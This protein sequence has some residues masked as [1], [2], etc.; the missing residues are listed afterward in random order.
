MFNKIKEWLVWL[1]SR[2]VGQ[3]IND[4]LTYDEVLTIVHEEM[5]RW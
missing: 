1:L 3:A 4:G 2:R 5:A